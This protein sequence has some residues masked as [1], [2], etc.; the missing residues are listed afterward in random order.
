MRSGPGLGSAYSSSKD[1]LRGCEPRPAWSNI[2]EG[3]SRCCRGGHGRTSSA[4]RPRTRSRSR[5]ARTLAGRPSATSRSGAHSCSSQTR[6][7]WSSKIL[8][9]INIQLI[10]MHVRFKFLC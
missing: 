6:E 5:P 2:R 10:K 8:N 4:C 7:A 3:S 9:V 1:I